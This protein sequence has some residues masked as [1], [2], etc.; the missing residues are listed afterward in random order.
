MSM[1][2]MWFFLFLLVFSGLAAQNNQ[3]QRPKIGLVLSGGGAKGLAHIGALKVIE[4][5]GIPIDYI[6]GT[7]MGSIIGG[8]YAIGYRSDDLE[9]I[10][11]AQNWDDLLLDRV[12]RRQLSLK[13]RELQDR[14]AASFP[15]EQ[16]HI[17]LPTGL[18]AGQNI[19]ALLSRLTL[20]AHHIE[21]F[22]DLPIPFRCIAT[23]IE[24]GEVVVLKD[25]YLPDAIRASMSI[26]SAFSPMDID[27]QLLVD[28]GLVRN[29]PVQDVREMGADIVIG[30]DVSSP[31]YTRKQLNSLVRIMQQSV[32]FMGNRSTLEQR[33]LCDYIIDPEVEDFSIMDFNKTSAIIEKGEIA[34]RNQYQTLKHLADSLRTNFPPK[35]D[36]RWPLTVDSLHIRKIY[37]QGLRNVSSATVKRMLQLKKNSWISP[38]QL[39]SAIE[40]VYGTQYF[41]RVSYKLEP[42]PSGV[43]LFV[44]VIE[45]TTHYLNVGVAYDNQ[46]YSSLLINA[47]F[48]NVVGQGSTVGIDANVGENPS[49]RASY[50]IYTGWKPGLGFNVDVTLRKWYIPIYA[51]HTNKLKAS[52][53]YKSLIANVGL[54]TTYASSFELG[55]ACEYK[56]IRLD[57]QAVPDSW[58]S[59]VSRSNNITTRGWI[60]SDT[61]NRQS[62]PTHGHYV[63]FVVENNYKVHLDDK[64]IMSNPVQRATFDFIWT[65]KTLPKVAISHGVEIGMVEGEDVAADQY[66]YLGGSTSYESGVYPFWG[67][68]FMN[69][70]ATRLF[71]WHTDLQW[72]F[73]ENLYA[74]AHYNYAKYTLQKETL[75]DGQ[76]VQ[77]CG[78]GLGAY[79]PIGPLNITVARS[80]EKKGPYLYI[81]LGHR[82][83]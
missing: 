62:F 6:S 41:E 61:M 23:A 36:T 66:L 81:V 80:P 21:D 30:V 46:L 26:P 32:N 59:S 16:S 48:R 73:R 60:R 70:T 68:K 2:Q 72:E 29:F 78:A 37:V 42:V 76:N 13:E 8:L 19:T 15:I 20:S 75:F 9:K 35:Q 10:M 45:K 4:E 74:T 58:D 51:F 65:N 39:D 7:S 55:G 64:K 79:T 31:L 82:F 5:L 77:G 27:G 43:N 18:V 53:D 25:G 50:F 67:L 63:N 11:L 71:C 57:P 49:L 28:G 12:S 38:D 40:R 54:R 56:Y 34:A 22:N 47:L 24:S 33:K 69:V 44:R 52:Y 17:S 3:S 14:Y 1:K 83:F